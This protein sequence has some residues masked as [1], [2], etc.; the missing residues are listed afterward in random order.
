MNSKRINIITSATST[1]L[2]IILFRGKDPLSTSCNQSHLAN[3]SW[4]QVVSPGILLFST[5]RL[6]R[7]KPARRSLRGSQ[8]LV[9]LRAEARWEVRFFRWNIFG[10]PKK[11][12]IINLRFSRHGVY[13][14]PTSEQYTIFGQRK[15]PPVL[16][17][18]LTFPAPTHHFRASNRCGSA[19]CG[20]SWPDLGCDLS[21]HFTR[22]WLS[23]VS[24]LAMGQN[25]LQ[26][27]HLIPFYTLMKPKNS[28]DGCSSPQVWYSHGG[29]FIF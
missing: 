25:P 28:S 7:V 22:H 12:K 23:N 26:F 27:Y 14:A 5:S 6:M 1:S 18:T 9:M 24:N 11:L 20:T 17:N 4:L 8:Q 21:E 19:S 16:G 10:T 3:L 2:N 13:T 29:P 15:S